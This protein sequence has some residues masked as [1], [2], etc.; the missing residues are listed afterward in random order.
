MGLSS[1]MPSNGTAQIYIASLTSPSTAFPSSPPHSASR[2]EVERLSIAVVCK[3]EGEDESGST[4]RRVEEQLQIIESLSVSEMGELRKQLEDFYRSTPR[5]VGS[6]SKRAGLTKGIGDDD[7]PDNTGCSY[8]RGC[9]SYQYRR[10]KLP[11]YSRGR[12]MSLLQHVAK[13]PR[14]LASLFHPSIGPSIG[15]V[16]F[17][18]LI[19]RANARRYEEKDCGCS[20][21]S[22]RGL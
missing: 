11:G 3:M 9:S 12:S 5:R 7:A 6:R 17:A 10:A 15:K 16:S 18:P 13:R 14:T 21:M 22:S 4:L 8:R 19:P 1:R 2:I 20:A